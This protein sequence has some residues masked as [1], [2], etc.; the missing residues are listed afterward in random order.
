MPWAE[1]TGD[2]SCRVRYRRD[3]GT[4][5]SIP[6]FPD[7]TAADNYRG[8]IATDKR[9]GQW[10][11]RTAGRTTVA[12]WA[13]GP[14]LDSL[15]VDQA[16]RRELPQL[17]HRPH[18]P[19]GQHRAG[20]HHQLASMGLGEQLRNSGL[21]KSTVA[22]ILKCFTL[23][24]SDAVD[25]QPIDVNPSRTAAAAD[26]ALNVGPARSGPNPPMYSPSPPPRSPSTTA[27][28]EQC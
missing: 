23:I 3:D 13:L 17:P 6:G 16:H 24:L 8:H 22:S 9:R 26:D 28:A 21:A 12:E 7:A 2:G 5:G 19:M 20:R 27:P 10:H 15:G 1:Q 11:D 25:E 4:I 18:L 14:W